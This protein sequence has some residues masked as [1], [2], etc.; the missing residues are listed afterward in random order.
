MPV[1]KY[2]NFDDAEKALW[3]FNPDA[4]Y[5]SRIAELWKFADKISPI[6][7]P[8]GIFKFRNVEEAN[9][10]R[11]EWELAYAKRL[12]AKKG[13]PASKHKSQRP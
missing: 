8:Q 7:Y 1:Y 6:N 3:N 4:T 2:K 5:F 9:R 12:Q 11:Y 10:Q 13:L